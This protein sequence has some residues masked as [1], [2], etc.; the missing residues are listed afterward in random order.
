L[1]E[2]AIIG[3]GSLLW[4]LDNLSPFVQGDWAMNAGPRLPLEFSLISRKRLGAL[5][6][7]ID[8][9]HGAYSPS[10]LILSMHSDIVEARSN[11]AARERT[12]LDGI[13]FI[14]LAQQSDYSISLTTKTLISPWL[15]QSGLQGA[16][17][18]DSPPNFENHTSQ[19][20]SVENAKRYLRSLNESS[21]REAKRYIT[22]A[23]IGVQSPL[24]L[25]L[26]Q[27]TWWQDIISL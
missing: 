3:W 17:W 26:A 27:E 5:A 15:R 24:R 13:G 18:T 25:S 1:S 11:L 20:F 6:L 19:T 12:A 2:I 10:S 16:V 4:D 21:L 14:D 7:A 8:E 23:P 9:K 22:K